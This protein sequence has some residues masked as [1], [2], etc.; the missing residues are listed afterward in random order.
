MR[1]EIWDVKVLQISL[2]PSWTNLYELGYEESA[3]NS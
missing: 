3:V 1:V 2:A